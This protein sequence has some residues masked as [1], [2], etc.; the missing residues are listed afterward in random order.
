[1]ASPQLAAT[2]LATAIWTIFTAGMV[3]W[4]PP[5]TSSGVQLATNVDRST[6][7]TLSRLEVHR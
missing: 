4:T 3:Y 2:L 7:R 1:M 6:A 5:S